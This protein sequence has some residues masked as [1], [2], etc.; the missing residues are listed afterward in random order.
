VFRSQSLAA[1]A[2]GCDARA[3]VK[4]IWREG[5]TRTVLPSAV[6]RKSASAMAAN[7]EP[8]LRLRLMLPFRQCTRRR[9]PVTDNV[10]CL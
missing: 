10:S 1:I 6:A 7:T 8:E 4:Q 9:I 2:L 5:G 3:I